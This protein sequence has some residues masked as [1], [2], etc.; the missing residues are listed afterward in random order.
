MK[1]YQKKV[2]YMKNTGSRHFEEAYFVLRSDLEKENSSCVEMIEEANR[3]IEEN[4][5]QRKGGFLYLGRWYI[6]AFFVGCAL[7]FAACSIIG[8]CLR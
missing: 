1:G 5:D 2:I 8:L 6:L 4:F 3:I 7:T